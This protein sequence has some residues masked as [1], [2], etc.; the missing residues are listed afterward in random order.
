M[1]ESMLAASL[2]LVAACAS[3][4]PIEPQVAPAS[5]DFDKAEMVEVTLSNFEFSPETIRLQAG[6]PCALVLINAASGGHDFTAPEFFAAASIMAE[7]ADEV[8]T[9]QVELAGGA[10]VTIHLVPVA[11]QYPL[12]CT[13]L[14][15]AAFGMKGTIVVL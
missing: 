15:H 12:V 10:T 7:D 9:G 8:A 2:C 4:H 1:R 14:G 13:H 6:A 3:T 11:G 5:V